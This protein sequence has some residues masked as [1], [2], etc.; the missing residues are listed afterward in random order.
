MSYPTHLSDPCPYKGGK[1]KELH[2]IYEN[3]PKSFT[4]V[5]DVFGGGG[6]V[7]LNYAARGFVVH[8]N[9]KYE[10]LVRMWE[11]LQDSEKTAT[12]QERC[13]GISPTKDK[14]DD[15]YYVSFTSPDVRWIVTHTSQ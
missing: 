12:F 2:K 9:D 11:M 14:H 4:R 10:D 15:L 13:R 3:E 5:V 8:Y 6:S 7:S 1:Y